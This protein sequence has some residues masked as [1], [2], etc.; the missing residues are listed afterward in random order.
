MDTKSIKELLESQF[1]PFIREEQY[2]DA[3][4]EA[5]KVFDQ[6]DT[7]VKGGTDPFYFFLHQLILYLVERITNLEREI[8]GYR[9][10]S[11]S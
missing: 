10:V 5:I 9:A 6:M 1:R 11:N 4:D 2:I 3:F 8:E 7:S